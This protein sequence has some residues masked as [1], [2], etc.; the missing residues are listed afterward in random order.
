MPLSL[1]FE[2]YTTPVHGIHHKLPVHGTQRK[3]GVYVGYFSEASVTLIDG[4][5]VTID[6]EALELEL[7]AS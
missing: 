3:F 1:I 6:D 4:L 2:V 7:T 5:P